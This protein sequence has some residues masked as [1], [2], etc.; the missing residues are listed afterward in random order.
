MMRWWW[1]GPAVTHDELAKELDQ[2]HSAGIGGVEIQ[3]VYPL[4]VDDPSKGIKNLPYLSPAFLEAVTFANSKARSLGMRVDIT[5]GSGWPYGGPHTTLA[6]AASRL[7]IITKPVSSDTIALPQLAEG[8]TLIAAFEVSGSDTLNAKQLTIPPGATTLHATPQPNQTALFFV[9]SHTKQ[10]VKRPSAGAE[11]LVLD[12]FSRTAVDA[13]LT[14][15]ATPLLSAFGAT[16]PFSVFSDSLEVYGADWTPDL[17]AEFQTRRGY[18][19]TPHLPELAHGDTPQSEA[20]RH[21]W[22]LTLSELINENYLSQV[23]SFAIRQHTRFRSQ[24]YGEPAVTLSDEAT[25]QLPEGEGPQWRTFSFTRWAASASHL[26]GRNITSAETWTWLHSPAFRATP[27]DMKVEADRMF[28]QGVNQVIGHGWP[29]SPTSVGEPG[30]S[31]YAAAV[32]NTHNPWW[33]VMPNVM[34]YLHRAS[35]LLRQGEPANDVAILLPEDDAQAA[36]SPGHVSV[37]DEMKKRITPELMSTI[38]DAGYNVDYTDAATINRLGI[39]HPILILPPMDRIPLATAE[40]IEAYAKGGGRVV[41]I[42]QTSVACSW[43]P[44][45]DRFTS[46]QCHYGPSHPQL[47]PQCSVDPVSRRAYENSPSSIAARSCHHYVRTHH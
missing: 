1:F 37:T 17:L 36:F 23:N 34:N 5:L 10:T 7:R 15:V 31:F 13:H 32:F 21:D 11:G 27:L 43:T 24:T 12:H 9:A 41:A 6:N 29:Y 22:G 14:E 35:W 18:D 28:L 38:L 33:P 20:V 3:P 40:T 44:A 19:L 42:E 47:R 4:S 39:H 8:E 2:M 30:W 25:P 16:P 26:Y 45:A 46:N